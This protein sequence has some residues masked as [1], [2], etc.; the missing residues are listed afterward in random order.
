MMGRGDE[1]RMSFNLTS[2][3]VSILIK[4][5]RLHIVSLNVTFS[6]GRTVNCFS[7]VHPSKFSLKQEDVSGIISFQMCLS[8]HH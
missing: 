8:L 2:H 1:L 6:A 7:D 4:P 5:F 3:S